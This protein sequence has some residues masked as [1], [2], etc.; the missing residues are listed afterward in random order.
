MGM[1][2]YLEDKNLKHLR[3]FDPLKSKKYPP[4]KIGYVLKLLCFDEKKNQMHIKKNLKNEIEQSFEIA[5]IDKIFIP[6]LAKEIVK[7]QKIFFSQT[8]DKTNFEVDEFITEL[9]LNAN[10]P[11]EKKTVFFQNFKNLISCNCYPFSLYLLNGEIINFIAPNLL[12]FND[13]ISGLN[14]LMK[15]KLAPN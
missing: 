4:E 5:E 10:I 3:T 1:Q 15:T 11:Q 13:I 8:M 9:A 14:F 2:V 7:L 12:T 6:K